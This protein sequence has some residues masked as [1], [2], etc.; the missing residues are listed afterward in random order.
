MNFH[1][2]EK[3]PDIAATQAC[4]REPEK[5]TSQGP[6]KEETDQLMQIYQIIEE[7][8]NKAL[9]KSKLKHWKDNTPKIEPGKR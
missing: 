9:T 5:I 6:W 8:T 4:V 1:F 7:I 2:E 3:E